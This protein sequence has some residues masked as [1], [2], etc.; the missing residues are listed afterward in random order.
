[1]IIYNGKYN[2]S[3]KKTNN[4]KPITWWPGSYRLTIID[5]SKHRPGVYNLKPVIVLISNTGEGYSAIN[6]FQNLAKSIC[7]DFNLDISR[8]LWIE[9][10]PKESAH[11]EVAVFKPITRIGS[12]TI[13]SVKW[14]PIMPNEMELIKSYLSKIGYVADNLNIS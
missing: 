9:Y 6:Y 8:T 14:R 11:M 5:I 10:L 13:Y 4:S 2:W 7:R 3:G 1:M 12:E